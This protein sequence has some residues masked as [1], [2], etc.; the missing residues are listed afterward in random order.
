MRLLVLIAL[1]TAA[2]LSAAAAEPQFAAGLVFDDA[3]RNGRPDAGERGL[4]E[5]RV[6]NGREIVATDAQGRYRLPVDD[7]AII[8]VIKPRGWMTPLS[9][10]NLPQF[11]YIHKPHGSP[12]S[13]SPYAGVAPTGPLPERIDF[14][15]RRQEEPDRFRVLVFGDPQANDLD[16]ITFY[17]HDIVAEVIGVDAAFGVSLGDLAFDDLTL[18]DALNA[19]TAKIGLPWYNIH[20]NHDMNYH[21]SDDRYADETFERI[22][23]PACYA[24]EYGPVAFLVLDDVRSL[25]EKKYRAGLGDRQLAFVENYVQ[26]LPQAQLVVL[27]CHIPL[28][29][30]PDEEQRRLFAPFAGR[31]RTLALT[32][33]YHI[34]KH[35]WF[36][37]EEGFHGATPLHHL[38]HATACG[39]WWKGAPDELGLPH[40]MMRD[41]GPNGYSLVTF[42]GNEYAIRFKAARRPADYQMHI[43]APDEV[44]QGDAGATPV[45]VNVFTGSDRSVVELRVG[46][47]GGVGA[48]GEGGEEGGVGAGVGGGV[49]AWV[50]LPQVDEVD[51][52]YL[53]LKRLEESQTPPHGRKMP[54]QVNSPHLWRGTLP[55]NLPAGVHVLEARTTDLFG[56][57]FT[58]RRIIRVTADAGETAAR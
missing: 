6:S 48:R 17:A 49:G 45:Y 25:G 24:F 51:P 1:A 57:Q 4:P 43:H 3:N 30:L 46:V 14:A 26:P 47:E 28:G 53:Q 8:F 54:K 37:P 7:D 21:A 34:Q 9:E 58:A 18:F 56:Q 42:A 33:H 39:S 32:A 15:L 29:E 11:H 38:I 36:G 16:D 35:E 12:Q 2:T 5:V 20:G 23:G 55:A 44:A 10:Q 41:G 52:Y 13:E 50:R 31:A 22:Y 40:T 27:L 19:V